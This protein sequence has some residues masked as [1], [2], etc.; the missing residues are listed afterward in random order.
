M[1]NTLLDLFPRQYLAVGFELDRINLGLDEPQVLERGD[2]SARGRAMVVTA[3]PRAE[4]NSMGD[5]NDML[6]EGGRARESSFFSSFL[7]KT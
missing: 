6:G 7:T 2:G 5:N 1:W 4:L 3:E